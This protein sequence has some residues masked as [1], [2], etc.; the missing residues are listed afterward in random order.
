M[1]R[2]GK[3]AAQTTAD[4]DRQALFEKLALRPENVCPFLALATSRA[5]YE[6][7]ATDEHRCYAFGDPEPVS[8]EYQ[9]NVCLQRGY[10]NCPR[11][12]RGVLVIPSDEL[13]ALRRPQQRVPPPPPPPPPRPRPAPASGD[14]GRRRGVAALLVLLLLVAGG[15]GAWWIL[16]GQG[17]GVARETPSPVSSPTVEPEPSPS[18]A[19]PSPS[20]APSIAPT[21]GPEDVFIGYE[22]GV[23]EGDNTVFRVND[24]GQI[25]AQSIQTFSGSSQGPVDRVEATNGLLHWRETEGPLAG[26]SFI[27]DRSGEFQIREVYQAP[28]GSLR[29]LTLPEDET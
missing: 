8:L 5:D 12:L 2:R 9:R 27:R 23:G 13:E 25:L 6:E 20:A 4:A 26:W 28:D 11:Y 16:A 22:V 7:Q 19:Q 29:W 15:V 3:S 1:F 21:P 14:G 17:F 18:E 10:A 24:G